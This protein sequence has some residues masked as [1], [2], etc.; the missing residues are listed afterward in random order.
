M[1]VRD[2]DCHQKCLTHTL[3][4]QIFLDRWIITDINV[5]AREGRMTQGVD[6]VYEWP[7]DVRD[8]SV[9]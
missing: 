1:I 7:Y 6:C 9:F 4:L 5:W 2:I 8:V 3:N